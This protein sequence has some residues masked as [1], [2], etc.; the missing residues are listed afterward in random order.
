MNMLR[1]LI[2]AVIVIYQRAISPWKVLIFQRQT[3]R[4]FPSCSEYAR[5]SLIQSGVLKGAAKSIKRLLSCHP[6]H[7][8]GIDL[9]S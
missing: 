4:F 2:V 8:G 7:P 9:P 6:F 5:L 1:K 3:C